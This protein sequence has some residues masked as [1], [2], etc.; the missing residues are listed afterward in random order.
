MEILEQRLEGRVLVLFDGNCAL[1][2][3]VVRWLIRRDRL[4][5]LRFVPVHNENVREIS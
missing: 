5:R 1:C 2:N 3:G 4:D